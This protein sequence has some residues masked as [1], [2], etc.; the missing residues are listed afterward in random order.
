MRLDEIVNGPVGFD[1]SHPSRAFD[2]W[3]K[4]SMVDP[5]VF[6]IEEPPRYAGT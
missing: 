2:K 6:L 1:I 3:Q 4:I 5:D